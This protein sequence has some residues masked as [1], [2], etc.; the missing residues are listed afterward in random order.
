MGEQIVLAHL[1]GVSAAQM[2]LRLGPLPL[3]K[4]AVGT[5]SPQMWAVRGTGLAVP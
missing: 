2:K 5:L 1:C 4:P 3:A